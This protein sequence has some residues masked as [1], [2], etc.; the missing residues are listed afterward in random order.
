MK[1][2][3][4]F[5]IVVF[6]LFGCNGFIIKKQVVKDYYLTAPDVEEQ[7]SLSYHTSND[8][9]SY[10]TIVGETVFAIGFNDKYI[11]V[12]QHPWTYP[13]PPDTTQ[14]NYY[15]LP[16]KNGMD[17]KSKNGLMGPLTLEQ[18]NEKC[19]E[20]NMSKDLSFTNVSEIL[21]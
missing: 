12:K 7:L 16:L 8:G 15:I 21:K 13:N 14:T 10:G 5:I 19:I 20:L 9:D 2:K 1:N 17:W 18:F 6:V 4:F 3:I 11:I